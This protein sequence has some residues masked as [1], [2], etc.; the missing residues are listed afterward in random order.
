MLPTR[1]ATREREAKGVEF[2]NQK[3]AG[4][5]PEFGWLAGNNADI[6][7]YIYSNEFTDNLA[8]SP[9]KLD[10]IPRPLPKFI[11]STEERW[12]CRCPRRCSWSSKDQQR[13]G[14]TGG[15]GQRWPSWSWVRRA[16]SPSAPARCPCGRTSSQSQA[17]RRFIPILLARRRSSEG[18][19]QLRENQ[20]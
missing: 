13:W 16:R 14:W 3:E 5:Y 2:M 11:C 12:P 8:D 10:N 7:I 17:G 1:K 18:S 9:L 6:C 15:R 20:L 4:N 19:A